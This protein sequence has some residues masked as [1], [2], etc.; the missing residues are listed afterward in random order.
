[1]ACLVQ[2]TKQWMQDRQTIKMR[3]EKIT[4]GDILCCHFLQ[5]ITFSSICWSPIWTYVQLG[6]PQ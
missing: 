1:M 4:A 3:K 5:Y 6:F 2:N